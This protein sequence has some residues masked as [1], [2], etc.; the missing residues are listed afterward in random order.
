MYSPVTGKARLGYRPSK[1]RIKHMF[2]KLHALT[3]RAGTWQETTRLVDQLNLALRRWANYF[4]ATIKAYRALDNYTAVRLRR[5]LRPK[6]KVRRRKGGSYPLSHLYGPPDERGGNKYARPT[7]TAPHLDSTESGRMGDFD[8]AGLLT[9]SPLGP[10][11]HHVGVAA[12]ARALP[13]SATELRQQL[14]LPYPRAR[15]ASQLGPL[16]TPWIRVLHKTERVVCKAPISSMSRCS[17]STAD[18]ICRQI[19]CHRFRFGNRLPARGFEPICEPVDDIEL[20]RCAVAEPLRPTRTK[21][22][23]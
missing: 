15:C 21:E 14:P 13:K 20:D 23:Y 9:P 19:Q 2:E 4:C 22:R 7:T 5:W 10:G 11:H 17:R 12:A 1:K 3:D 16:F 8:R 18:F 6:H